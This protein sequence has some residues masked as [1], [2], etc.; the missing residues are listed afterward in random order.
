MDQ[1]H[2]LASNHAGVHVC[3][4]SALQTAPIMPPVDPVVT[5]MKS[6]AMR[7]RRMHNSERR[8][9]DMAR[10]VV[11]AVRA[12]TGVNLHLAPVIR[13]LVQATE[14]VGLLLPP[15]PQVRTS[16]KKEKKNKVFH[17]WC[18]LLLVVVCVRV[19]ATWII[20]IYICICICICVYNIYICICVYNIYMYMCIYVS[21]YSRI[22]KSVLKLTS[23]SSQ[24]NYIFVPYTY[25]FMP[26][27]QSHP[28]CRWCVSILF[29]IPIFESSSLAH[30]QCTFLC[31]EAQIELQT[32]RITWDASARSHVKTKRWAWK[33]CLDIKFTLENVVSI[34]N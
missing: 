25:I 31:T 2:R 14:E 7:D 3:G 9:G 11:S 13:L 8:V 29:E 34:S 24:R 12:S 22:D 10:R 23:I 32:W 28:R 17:V 16:C 26:L 27:I 18:S 30:S 20:Y 33:Y 5:R 6:P 21:V 4:C 1:I 19:D 15:A